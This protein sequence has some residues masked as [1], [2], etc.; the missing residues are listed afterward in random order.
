M[1]LTSEGEV[2]MILQ[3]SDGPLVLLGEERS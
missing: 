2:T 1:E 3:T